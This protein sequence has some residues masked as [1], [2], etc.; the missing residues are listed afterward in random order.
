MSMTSTTDGFASVR[1]S[2]TSRDAE[3]T[4]STL[5][6]EYVETILLN[7]DKI[8]NIRFESYIYYSTNTHT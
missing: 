2:V 6:F 3:T 1:E 5:D 4:A 8:F 7:R